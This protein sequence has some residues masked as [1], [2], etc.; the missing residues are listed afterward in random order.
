MP[1]NPALNLSFLKI[2]QSMNQP[3]FPKKGGGGLIFDTIIV[4]I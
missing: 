2:Y 1:R 4:L 3:P